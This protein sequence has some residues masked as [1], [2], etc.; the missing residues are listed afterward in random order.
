[1]TETIYER[2]SSYAIASSLM[3]FIYSKLHLLINKDWDQSM[4][5]SDLGCD[6]VSLTK[7]ID[8]GILRESIIAIEDRTTTRRVK[9]TEDNNEV[10]VNWLST[11]FAL[12]NTIFITC[13]EENGQCKWHEISYEQAM[14]ALRKWEQS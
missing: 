2:H 11:G 5:F 14:L 7:D 12:E 4:L 10:I 8:A 9:V 13:Y 6:I 3:A 1:M